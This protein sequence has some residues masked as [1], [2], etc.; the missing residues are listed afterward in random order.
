MA[1]RLSCS[2]LLDSSGVVGRDGASRNSLF[3]AEWGV[4]RFVK[5][6]IPAPQVWRVG[7]VEGR[8]VPEA[9]LRFP[10]RRS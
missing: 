2:S 10:E 7:T 8:D 1:I 3:P 4:G 6:G 5:I 9:R